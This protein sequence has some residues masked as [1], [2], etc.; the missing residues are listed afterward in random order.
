[1]YGNDVVCRVFRL[2]DNVTESQSVWL[3]TGETEIT[4]NHRDLPGL[5]L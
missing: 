5:W 3:Q 4:D 2:F 1:M